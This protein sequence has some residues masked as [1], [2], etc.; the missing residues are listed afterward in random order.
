MNRTR[1]ILTVK[2]LGMCWSCGQLLLLLQRLDLV[3]KQSN[4]SAS[5]DFKSNSL[6]EANTHRGA[7]RNLQEKLMGME[8]L[9]SFP[10]YEVP[11]NNDT[12]S[13]TKD[14]QRNWQI[15]CMVGSETSATASSSSGKIDWFASSESPVKTGFKT[16]SSATTWT[17]SVPCSW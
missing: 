15:T 11:F 8:T 14:H 13:T 3:A 6:P 7:R 5:H 9:V 16:G 1:S 4:W 10:I 17:T 2:S 12:C